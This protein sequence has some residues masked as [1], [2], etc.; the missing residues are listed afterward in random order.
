[1]SDWNTETADRIEQLVTTVRART[2][3]PAETASRAVVFGL[4]TAFFVGTAAVLVAIMGFRLLAI[5]L[6]VWAAWL[7]LGGI[8]MVGGALCWV[9]RSRALGKAAGG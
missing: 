1:M 5:G 7:V 3:G 9:I 8:F 2:V 4:L 6:P